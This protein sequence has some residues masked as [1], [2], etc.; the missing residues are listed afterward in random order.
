MTI[1]I[2]VRFSRI[3]SRDETNM[4]YGDNA[5]VLRCYKVMSVPIPS[6]DEC[7]AYFDKIIMAKSNR[8]EVKT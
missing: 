7:L 4:F 2:V 5:E 1:A 6:K 8:N 3:R